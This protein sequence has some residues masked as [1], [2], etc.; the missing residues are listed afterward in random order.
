M[1]NTLTLLILLV[2]AF[3]F[4]QRLT[5]NQT[6]RA[7]C[8]DCTEKSTTFCND[9]LWIKGS[10]IDETT[11]DSLN[12]KNE[13]H[14]KKQL[15]F[16]PVINFSKDKILKKYKNVV[17]KKS[18]L[19]IVFKS[20]EKIENNL[21][22]IQSERFKA[23]LNNKKLLSDKEVV[24]NK[25]NPET[26]IIVSYLFNKDSK[27]GKKRG[28]L[29]FDDLLL[30]D[31]EFK[32][33]LLELIY[34]PKCLNDKDK[35]SIESYLSI[36]Y[37]ISLNEDKSYYNFK[38]DKIWNAEENKNFNKRVTGI[39]KEDFFGL[40]QMQSFNSLGDGLTIGVNNIKLSNT[41]NKTLLADE[42]FIIWGD[43][44][45]STLLN[46]QEKSTVK[47]I[48]RVWKLNTIAAEGHDYKTQIRIDK[49]LMVFENEVNSKDSDFMW[50]AIDSSMSSKFNYEN[51]K[52]IKAF[53]NNENEIVFDKVHFSANSSYLFTFV[54]GPEYV[55]LKENNTIKT[56]PISQSNSGY[57]IYPN[58]VAPYEKFYIQFNIKEVSNV[59]IQI[60]DVNGKIIKSKEL[61]LIDNHL[62]NESL[63]ASGTYLVLVSING[64]VQANKLIVK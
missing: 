2:F 18:T 33:Q 24:L 25:G 35:N 47:R 60:T 11:E 3:S 22:T 13:D 8:L 64:V 1:K 39:G 43:N 59:S 41:K 31:K 12:N 21:M 6:K 40:N 27:L 51:A 52:Y 58:P 36:K 17:N 10:E 46:K 20:N 5:S 9:C 42:T 63:S 49:R 50:I 32:N 30:N 62:Y 14:L 45:K 23:I 29:L 54:K 4:G 48:N 57:T 55:I 61:G 44:G 26:G 38:G 19:F 34:I 7:I 15:N 56:E 28:S 37:G 16:N 53:I